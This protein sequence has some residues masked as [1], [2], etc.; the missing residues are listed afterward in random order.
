MEDAA[1][2]KG[3]EGHLRT[4]DTDTSR[5]MTFYHPG[6]SDLKSTL[7]ALPARDRR[8][9]HDGTALTTCGHLA[10]NASKEA[11]V[12]RKSRWAARVKRLGRHSRGRQL[13]TTSL[14]PITAKVNGSAF[15]TNVTSPV[16]G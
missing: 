1:K 15:T 9:I 2:K 8:G 4:T 5:V 10:N 14:R 3:R 13:L 11:F 16:S 12:A 7:I 6:Y